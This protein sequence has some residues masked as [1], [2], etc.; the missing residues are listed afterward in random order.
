MMIRR[1]PATR[2]E[3]RRGRRGQ[4]M[5][6]LAL[7][8]PLLLLLLLGTIDVGRAFYCAVQLRN[9]VREGAGYGAHFP[10]DTSGMTSRVTAHG[11]PSGTTV[12]TPTLSGSCTSNNGVASGTCVVTVTASYAFTPVTTGFLQKYFGLQ[13]FTIS[14]SASMNV[15]Q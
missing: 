3:E 5:V 6:E 8:L 1:R 13:P 4:S 2:V 7:G 11:V 10:T 14:A 9:A 15:L 12:S